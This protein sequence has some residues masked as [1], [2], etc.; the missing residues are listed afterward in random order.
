MKLG[1]NIMLPEAV[2]PSVSYPQKYQHEA[3]TNFC[4]GSGASAT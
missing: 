1:M 3:G 4:G 2:Y